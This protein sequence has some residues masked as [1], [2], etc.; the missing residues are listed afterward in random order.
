MKTNIT[1]KFKFAKLVI[2]M[3]A[4]APLMAVAGS[5]HAQI[6][7]EASF[8]AKVDASSTAIDALISE[9]EASF[10][11][12]KATSLKVLKESRAASDKALYDA[13]VA[14]NAE[15]AAQFK[16][17][18][19]EASTPEQKAA[20]AAFKKTTFKAVE[21][22]R[23]NVDVAIARYRAGVDA[24]LAARSTS[25]LSALASLKESID[26]SLGCADAQ[27]A[28]QSKLANL[29]NSGETLTQLVTAR[30]EK[31]AAAETKFT[32]TITAAAATLKT[33]LG[34]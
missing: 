32:A 22:R 9:R 1:L 20:V 14:A 15:Y 11:H 26:Q 2:G 17:L 19:A 21:T 34:Q 30:N 27:N 12:G 18:L 23:A 16:T 10:V 6:I 7:P 31:V 4:I 24:I 3:A 13:R 8:C 29:N 25:Y 5:A 33:A 28:F